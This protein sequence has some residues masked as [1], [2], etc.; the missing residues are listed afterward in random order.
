MRK[1]HSRLIKPV[2]TVV[3][4]FLISG[5]IFRGEHESRGI[6]L[7]EAMNS[8]AK[9]DAQDLGG[10]HPHYSSHSHDDDDRRAARDATASAGFGT[11]SYN[12]REYL[13][14][15]P[16]GIEHTSPFSGDI[17]RLTHIN[18]TPIALE[19]EHNS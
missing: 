6:K 2:G 18:L 5:C 9:G 7:S 8:S 14:Q 1:L 12:E 19:D 4:S 17:R 11:V 16:L 3:L 13:W 15:V 10:S